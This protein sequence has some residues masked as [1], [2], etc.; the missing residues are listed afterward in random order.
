MEIWEP[1]PPGTLWTSPG[2][3]RDPS[4]L[5][6]STICDKLSLTNCT[7]LTAD[8]AA[9]VT[10]KPVPLEGFSFSVPQHN[11]SILILQCHLVQYDILYSH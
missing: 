2:L 1:K 3:L 6:L 10:K 8:M 5:L 9:S 7:L 11:Y 4:T